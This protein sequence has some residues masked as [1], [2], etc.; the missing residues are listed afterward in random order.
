[1]TIIHVDGLLNS[2]GVVW[3]SVPADRY[4]IR[5]VGVEGKETGVNSKYPG[6][7]MLV[8]TIGVAPGEPHEGVRF[9]SYTVLPHEDMSPMERQRAL[10]SV[11]SL[12]LAFGLDIDGD[13]FDSD[14][15]LDCTADAIIAQEP[16]KDNPERLI[17]TVKA[18]VAGE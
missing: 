13:E 16:A 18:I 15:L 6:K 4:P 7:P 9:T 8:L 10:D 5:V 17:N 1:M 3:K 2:D 12:I 14:E 11:K